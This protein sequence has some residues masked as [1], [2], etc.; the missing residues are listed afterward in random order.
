M[1]GRTW[2]LAVAAVAAALGGADLA[3]AQD[4]PEY[5]CRRTATAPVIDG[6]GDDAAWAA[7]EAVRLVDVRILA[8]REHPHATEVRLTW[9]AEALYVLF[10]A[11]DPDVWS[12]LSERDDPLYNEEV[13]ELFLD[14]DG[15]G[16]NY[17]EIEIN[18]LNT[19]FDLLVTKALGGGGQGRPEWSPEGL[20]SAV[21]VNGTLNAP[22]D[23]DEGWVTEIA[24]PWAALRSDLIDVP[25]D[26]PLPPDPGDRWRA[27]LYRYER[28]RTAA[29]VASGDIEYSAWSPV[30]RV[31]FHVPERFGVV[32][33]VGGDTAVDPVTWA[34]VKRESAL[35]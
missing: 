7:A 27:N 4:L 25:G 33:F 14:P 10:T 22:G 32:A 30:G 13:V 19:V 23:A 9:D 28:P 21:R 31:D 26:R 8:G 12:T 18:P 34:A 2:K 16:L 35:R 1:M 15:D 20:R 5:T 29:G 6:G 24:L 11:S 17:A 3:A